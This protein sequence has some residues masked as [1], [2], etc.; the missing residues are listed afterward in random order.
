MKNL[1]DECKPSGN[2]GNLMTRHFNDNN[3][4]K[5]LIVDDNAFSRLNL[6]DILSLEG[7][8]VVEGDQHIDVISLVQETR[9]DLILLELTLAKQNPLAIC[10]T[11]K[12]SETELIP[13]V[14]MTVRR[15]RESRAQSVQ[16]GADD[17]LVKPIDRLEL[18]SRVKSLIQQKRLNQ[19]LEEIEEVL[20][21]I[22]DIL[23]NPHQDNS[24]SVGKLAVLAQ[25]FG[26]Y[27]QLN[28]K[29]IQSLICAAYLHDIGTITIPESIMLKTG[30][31]T[32][33]EREIVNQHVLVG[34]KI[35]QPLQT[36]LDILPIIR[37]H[38]ERWD[39]SG[40]PD[41]LAGTDIPWLAQVFQLTDIYH[42]LTTQRPFKEA[43][44]PKQALEIISEEATKG[45]RNPQLVDEFIAFLCQAEKISLF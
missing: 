30:Q 23:E 33:E 35:C 8:E 42:A 10:Q 27:L 44:K 17:F 22:A 26:K 38:H 37:H 15:D 11:L 3:K 36:R 6:L 19:N 32:E 34:E 12:N 29:Q 14:F 39:G 5:I 4:G 20:F 7:Y 18:T 43:F 13:I 31:L 1:T 2:K 41:G 45:W 9:P 40:Y 21:R 16:A 25:E 28:P 24:A